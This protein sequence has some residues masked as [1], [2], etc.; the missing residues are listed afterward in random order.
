MS[1]DDGVSDDDAHV[2]DDGVNGAC[3]GCRY[4]LC[5]YCDIEYSYI[6]K[7]A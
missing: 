4:M 1:D 7:V 5:S 3:F 2:S 6:P